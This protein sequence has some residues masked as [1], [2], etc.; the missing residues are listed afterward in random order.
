M[1][2]FRIILLESKTTDELWITHG[3][4]DRT[5]APDYKYE[6]IS[7]YQANSGWNKK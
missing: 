2:L 6:G 4:F 5:Y 3:G 7:I 1:V